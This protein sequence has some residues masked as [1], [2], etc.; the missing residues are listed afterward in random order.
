M[1]QREA[2]PVPA[3]PEPIPGPTEVPARVGWVETWATVTSASA[4]SVRRLW[5]SN[6]KKTAIGRQ[7]QEKQTVCL[8]RR[9][10]KRCKVGRDAT[11]ILL[12]VVKTT[13]VV[14]QVNGT[15]LR[16]ISVTLDNGKSAT[17]GSMQ[18]RLNSSSPRCQSAQPRHLSSDEL[19]IARR[20]EYT[21]PLTG[22]PPHMKWLRRT[23][24]W[25]S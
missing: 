19:R 12:L 21:P 10:R 9:D 7:P 13:A 8:P 20:L 6:E 14:W 11:P 25:G 16:M 4:R 22:L 23:S 3:G 5:I 18:K 24:P 2:G 17:R 1:S 15:M